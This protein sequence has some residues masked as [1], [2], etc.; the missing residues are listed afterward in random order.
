MGE[1]T[2]AED[3]TQKQPGAWRE[4]WQGFN[5]WRKSRWPVRVLILL[6][7]FS[8]PL[9]ERLA[10]PPIIVHLVRMACDAITLSSLPTVAYHRQRFYLA[11]EAARLQHALRRE[12]DTDGNR[13]LSEE[14][15]AG[16]AA[17]GLSSGE[18]EA[19]ATEAD[20]AVLAE[21]A[22]RAGVLPQWYSADEVGWQAWYA[23]QAFAEQMERQ[24][25]ARW[26]RLLERGDVWPDYTKW[27]TWR[28]GIRWF[29]DGVLLVLLPG[30]MDA[31]VWYTLCFVAGLAAAT[32]VSRR[33][34]LLGFAAGAGLTL[35]L[36][37]LILASL[38]EQAPETA[39]YGV[40]AGYVVLSG[41][42][43]SVGGRAAGLCKRRVRARWWSALVAG[44]LLTVMG[45]IGP[46]TPGGSPGAHARPTQTDA[47]A[48]AAAKV[49]LAI[50]I[51]LLITVAVH[52]VRSATTEAEAPAE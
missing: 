45:L 49:M 40:T 19:K 2:S 14:E 8:V 15:R 34:R 10:R 21:A 27:A 44:G 31:L 6:I 26:Q 50:G 22:K 48:A 4:A 18:L 38:A 33:R 1:P 37:F 32:F 46:R 29:T 52:V 3:A 36:A 51:A 30:G 42:V 11:R 24:A 25:R 23:S 9:Y 41:A 16:L 12:L 7:I 17:V 35:I 28:S 39:W 43:A 47:V 13:T 20:L 5:R